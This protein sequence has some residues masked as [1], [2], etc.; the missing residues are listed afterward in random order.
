MKK[1]ILDFGYLM[2]IASR[3]SRYNT[4]TGL[5]EAID[6]SDEPKVNSKNVSITFG[7]DE[8]GII[9]TIYIADDGLS[10]P[11]S[12]HVDFWSVKK[13]EVK[14]SE[15]DPETLGKFGV[16]G[17]AGPFSFGDTICLITKRQGGEIYMSTESISNYTADIEPEIVTDE[18]TIALFNEKVNSSHGTL[19]I[20]K[21][22]IEDYRI[23]NEEFIEKDDCFNNLSL[24]YGNSKIHHTIDGKELEKRDIMGGIDTKTGKKVMAKVLTQH[25]E[26]MVDGC[27][28]PMSLITFHRYRNEDDSIEWDYDKW[29]L[30]VERNGR[31]TTILPLRDSSLFGEKGRSH[32]QSEFGAILSVKNVHDDYLNMP[33]SKFITSAEKFNASLLEKLSAQLKHDIDTSASDFA[34]EGNMLASER[35]K[36][37]CAKLAS[38]L[39]KRLQKFKMSSKYK[40]TTPK[41]ENP[42]DGENP[43]SEK[44]NKVHVNPKPRKKK[45][46]RFLSEIM[47]GNF[48]S[49]ADLI[50]INYDGNN[51][52]SVDIN[53]AHPLFA[54]MKL[55]DKKLE[56]MI[57]Y[58]LCLSM[59]I[60]N[61]MYTDDS[62]TFKRLSR[63]REELRDIQERFVHDMERSYALMINGDEADD[64]ED[65]D[66]SFDFKNLK[67]CE[68][69]NVSF[70]DIEEK[71]ELTE[72]YA[73][74]PSV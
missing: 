20:I 18:E 66:I 28:V 10:M 34:S 8:N 61:S 6:N 52:W 11:K 24:I 70:K 19:I 7:N 39:N 21:D 40:K 50:N 32:R 42:V 54:S 45:K 65:D 47:F 3:Y 48:G 64:E 26:I 22:L 23:T 29:G 33:Y 53:T 2:M 60:E 14:F 35:L 5:C 27:S 30:M 13:D 4:V 38:N 73:E 36:L 58:E 51:T 62:R 37:K 12:E 15:Y 17:K 1:P 63:N 46:V 57:Y 55:N 74:S 9:N 16:G 69:M 68:G 41:D 44:N 72:S 43:D 67:E 59:A 25:Y 49:K 31:I 56:S 71:E